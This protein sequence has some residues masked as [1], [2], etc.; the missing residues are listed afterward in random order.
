[1]KN[2]FLFCAVIILCQQV[3]GGECPQISTSQTHR[4]FA[5]SEGL[6]I[7]SDGRDVGGIKPVDENSL[8]LTNME[9]EIVAYSVSQQSGILIPDF[10]YKIYD[11]KKVYLGS[12]Q[13]LNHFGSQNE[14][15]FVLNRNRQWVGRADADNYDRVSFFDPAGRLFGQTN[16]INGGYETR[17]HIDE[18]V[19][20]F[21][22]LVVGSQMGMETFLENIVNGLEE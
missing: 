10:E 22:S 4:I 1:M 5:T 17:G 2:L 7:M 20:I 8:A 9:N 19:G 11:C 6:R 15:Y 12:I 13:T 18:R 21:L 3:M 14:T 16:Y